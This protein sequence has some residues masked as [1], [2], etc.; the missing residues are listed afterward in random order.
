MDLND[1]FEPVALEK[2]ETSFRFN[3][4]LFGR[5]LQIHT[6]SQPIGEISDF[7]V[8]ILGV[9]EDR[10]SANPGAAKA[11][12]QIRLKLYEL[13]RVNEKLR[14]IDLGN[15][16]QSDNV[17]D[18][19]FGLRDVIIDLLNNQVTALVLGGT[20]DL[21]QGV[22]M[23]LEAVRDSVSFVSVDARI[24]LENGP[25]HAATWLTGALKIKK[26]NLCAVMGQQQYLTDKRQ[27]A[28]LE[29]KSC[30]VLRLGNLRTNS[31]LAEPLIRDA[32]FM[33]F[34]MS[35]VRQAD[36]PGNRW[37][38]PNGLQAE[39]A[40][41]LARFAGLSESVACFGIFEVNPDFDNHGQTAHLAAQAA[42]YFMEG[43]SQRKHE[44]PAP[45]HPDF[46][47][48][49]VNHQD[50]EHALT[51]YK[52][53]ATGRWWMEVPELSTG[54]T[55]MIACSQEEYQQACNH[56]IPEFWWRAFQRIN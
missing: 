10:N 30:E 12:D 9:G 16:K 27:V 37:P 36:A 56:D 11:P 45:D 29:E 14:V 13:F 21:S 49:L 55:R 5:N 42:W 43:F 1:Y 48:Y 54:G 4:A 26:L 15:L 38:S 6:P 46:N 41:Q 53:L 2:P 23:A 24:D 35:A 44:Q 50:M 22:L 25:L 17:S 28:M 52:S 39:D 32:S 8:A 3:D 18:T 31:A 20:Q 34:D 19:Y 47:M 33:S 40:C 51:F 7:Q